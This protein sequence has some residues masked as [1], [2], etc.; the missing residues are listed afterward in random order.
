MTDELVER[1]RRWAFKFSGKGEQENLASDAMSEAADYIEKLE[2]KRSIVSVSPPTMT[3]SRG[4]VWKRNEDGN[5]CL[6]SRDEYRKIFLMRRKK[7]TYREIGKAYQIHYGRARQLFFR[8]MR[9]R[10]AKVEEYL[11]VRSRRG[12]Q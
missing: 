10:R 5:F 2:R 7:L 3:D 4:R 12:K 6:V 9:L 8:Y 11:E 1:L